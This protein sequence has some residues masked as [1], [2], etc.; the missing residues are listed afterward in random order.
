MTSF[1]LHGRTALVTGGFSGL[2][3]HFAEVLANH[4][5]RVALVGRRIELGRNVAHALGAK[6]GRPAD[7]RAYQADVTKSASVADAIA[8]TTVH[9][10]VPTIVI[11]NAGTVIRTPSL[12]VKD[13]D[14]KD[15]VDVN[16]SGV[17]KVAQASARALV[18]AGTPGS[19]INI[20]SILG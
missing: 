13:D 12:E 4:G 8:Q 16:L 6:I 9:F 14:W 3:L 5:A 19:I 7:V 1:D 11:N 2:G 17:F 18:K 20:A 15:V 10:G